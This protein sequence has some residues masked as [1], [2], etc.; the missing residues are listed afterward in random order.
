MIVNIHEAKTNLSRLIE[1]FQ[2]GEKI[3]IAKNGKPILQFA[4]VAENDRA[5]RT[6]GFFQCDV[7]MSS[8]HDPIEGMEEYL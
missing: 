8:F 4:Q 3:I 1:K 7:D 5:Q 2:A 6:L